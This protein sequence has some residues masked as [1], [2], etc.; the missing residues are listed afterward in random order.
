MK[1][2]DSFKNLF[3]KRELNNA[4]TIFGLDDVNF[5]KYLGIDTESVD[6][7]K[8]G[9]ITFFVCL[10]HLSECIGKLPVN[11][12]LDDDKKGKEKIRKNDFKTLLNLSPN[13]YMNATTF[14]Q[15]LELNRNY[16]GNAFVYVERF[17]V[18]RN[19]GK[20]SQLW[21][22]PSN[23]VQIWM[24]NDGIFGF[25]NAIWYIWTDS[26]TGKRYNFRKDEVL[27]F[28]SSMSW[29]GIVGIAIKDILAMQIDAAKY[30]Q[31]YLS[32][33]Y[34][35]NMFGGKIILQYTGQ[36]DNSA[37]KILVKE[38]ESYANSVGSGKFLPLPLGMTATQLDMKLSDAQFLDLNKLSA[39]QIA[40]AF[41]IKPNI[42]NDYSKSSYSNSETQ[43]V[44]FYVNSL[45][46]ILK[47]YKEE[48]TKGLLTRIDIDNGKFLEHDVHELFKMDP[49]RNMEY[50]V[51]GTN[52]GIITSNEAR[53]ILGLPYSENANA[54]E[55][56]ANGN[57]I[58][59]SKAGV[60]YKGGEGI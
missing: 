31:S 57:I 52:N 6:P 4:Q 38:I 16:Y 23:E 29:D 19:A 56:M 21:I 8:I 32:K 5:L 24:D 53:E 54:N 44:D 41:G 2:I 47:G 40:S 50:C 58:P 49:M 51:Q 34:K 15:T 9:E 43:Q 17:K 48:L 28:K 33:L 7:G 13:E 25:K 60:Q 39:L 27:H 30:G 10:K 36:L 14:W 37:K 55:L 45:M 46:P 22:M 35:G 11:L 3:K 26:R 59:L 1:I 20:V 42:I 18:G 12:Y